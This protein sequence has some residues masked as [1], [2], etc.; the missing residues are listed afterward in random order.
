MKRTRAHAIIFGKVQGV[1]FRAETQ[2]AANARG[3]NGWVRNRADGTV[4]AV[5]EGAEAGVVAV[6]EWCRKGPPASRV[7][8]VDVDWES[9]RREFSSFDI[10]Y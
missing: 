7:D 3:V 2:R 5:F 8:K 4:E 6:L 10:T 9:D 1:F